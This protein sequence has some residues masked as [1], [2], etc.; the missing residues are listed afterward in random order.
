MHVGNFLVK[1][2]YGVC[3]EGSLFLTA[4]LESIKIRSHGSVD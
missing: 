3:G 4:I 2:L 1:I